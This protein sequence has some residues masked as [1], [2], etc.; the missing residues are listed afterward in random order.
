M[1]LNKH[2]CS[3]LTAG[4]L[5]NIEPHITKEINNI[6][7]TQVPNKWSKSFWTLTEKYTST[8]LFYVHIWAAIDDMLN[9]SLKELN[10]ISQA[11]IIELK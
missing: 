3:F 6:K 11:W 7:E 5:V 2:I 10:D 4:L 1:T 8:I 9:F